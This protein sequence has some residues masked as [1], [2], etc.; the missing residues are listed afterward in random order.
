MITEPAKF[1]G[2]YVISAS[3]SLGW[4]GETSTCQLRLVEE[5]S[6]GVVF[7]PPPLGTCC[8]F[9]FGK[10]E[11]AG[12]LQRWTYSENVDSG[13]TYDVVLESPSKILDGVIVILNKF[14]GTFYNDDITANILNPTLRPDMTYGGSYPT[15][16]INIYADKENY[17]YGGLF[18]NADLNEL[19]YPLTNIV[20]DIKSTINRGLF[21]GKIVYSE[22]EF[23]LDLEALNEPLSYLGD[24]RTTQ[25]NP[26]I[27]S[28]ISD[29]CETGL[30]TFAFI[31]TGDAN[32]KGVITSNLKIKLIVSTRRSA[33]DPSLLYNHIQYLKG[34]PDDQKTL[35]TY[36]RGKE[37]SD[38]ISQKVLFGGPAS[39]YFFA[40]R[41]SF[42]PVWGKK[43][44]GDA[45][46]YYIGDL[47]QYNDFFR[48]ITAIVDGGYSGN[49]SIVTTDVLELRC[50]LGGR[51][52]WNFYHACKAYRDGVRNTFLGSKAN[53][54]Q[55]AFAALLR[56]N[57]IPQDFM[58]T[59]MEVA[60][61]NAAMA[62]Y[63][64]TDEQAAYFSQLAPA[65][66]YGF[67][68]NQRLIE[69]RWNSIE[70][71][72]K[73]HYGRQ[74]MVLVPGEPGGY[75]N[76]WRWVNFDVKAEQSWDVSSSAWSG[77][78]MRTFLNDMMFYDNDGGMVP[79]TFYELRDDMDYSGLSHQYAFAGGY[80]VGTPYSLDSVGNIV[81]W[82]EFNRVDSLGREF[83]DTYAFVPVTVPGIPLYDEYTSFK[84]GNGAYNL[85]NIF[86]GG[87]SADLLFKIFGPGGSSEPIV[88]DIGPAMAVPGIIGIPQ[89]SNR[90]VWGPWYSFNPTLGQKGKVS[91]IE[92]PELKPEVFGSVEDL[93]TY[94]QYLVNSEMANVHEVE[95]GSFELAEMPEYNLGERLVSNGPYVTSIS[96]NIGVDG[97][98]TTYDFKTETKTFGRI[99]QYNVNRIMKFNTNIFQFYKKIRDLYQ[100]PPI[101]TITP[102]MI[103]ARDKYSIPLQKP[104]LSMPVMMINARNYIEG[105]RENRRIDAS[106]STMQS[107]M[108]GA[109]KTYPEVALADW[110]QIVSPIE[111]NKNIYNA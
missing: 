39:R 108:A 19:G 28:L 50:A 104:E 49:F 16:V 75:E 38:D 71:I 11:F 74:F 6:E 26:S 42:F 41:T 105:S 68:Y 101:K 72:A 4:G 33:P 65:A 83:Q 94:G 8:K 110:S 59:S 60:A 107:A 29:I 103:E 79:T 88:I 23:D 76:N 52:A 73:N 85:M 17:K 69:A 40:D 56:G 99:A 21:G 92:N 98:R 13:R 57:I 80:G 62:R 43:G 77:K 63:Y 100:N 58:E 35:V 12:L 22:S 78:D 32:S 15:N 18:G 109:I 89:K 96:L 95:T 93:N 5:P 37:L 3:A 36:T 10:F 111:I 53:L 48:P 81:R 46:S 45:A 70:Y 55:Q 61:A 9:T 2:A 47:Q 84:T 97:V 27:L 66:R 31:V 102:S 14:Q 25:W 7:D 30:H 86:F 34:L 64:G 106:A 1:L 51:A 44:Q 20:N 67:I 24:Y 87:F 82:I 91:F 54:S 90:Y